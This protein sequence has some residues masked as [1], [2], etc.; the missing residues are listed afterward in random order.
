MQG[1]Y[2]PLLGVSDTGH[3]Q[4]M[5]PD[6]DYKF[7]GTKVTEYPMAQDG[8]WLEKFAREP[9]RQDATRNIAF[10]QANKMRMDNYRKSI[11]PENQPHISKWTPKPGEVER[12]EERD[13]QRRE[14]NSGLL[15]RLAAN[16]HVAK[17]QENVVLP[18]VDL[19]TLGEGAM[20][21]RAVAKPALEQ[22]SKYIAEKTALNP[23]GVVAKGIIPQDL[24]DLFNSPWSLYKE[25]EKEIK[26]I[27]LSAMVCAQVI[28]DQLEKRVS[29][30]RVPSAELYGALKNFYKIKLKS[31]GY[32]LVYEVIDHR[33]VIMIIA[34]GKRNRSEVY[35]DAYRRK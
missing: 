13:R 15:N 8:K 33:L 23:K 1:V 27:N 14:E 6:Q 20:A 17:L 4:M 7:D 19:Y 28:A 18:M 29:H 16:P 21:A 32:R 35:E 24:K 11:D 25:I 31:V 22:A 10:E 5:Y 2:E 34:V 3:T 12:M 26:D 30:P 9:M